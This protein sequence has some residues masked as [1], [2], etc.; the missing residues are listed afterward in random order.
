VL[1]E[2]CDPGQH[3][4]TKKGNLRQGRWKIG[5]YDPSVEPQGI[6]V[7][8]QVTELEVDWLSTNILDDGRSQASTPT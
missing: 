3:V 1:I 7:D 5:A 2:F 8:V 4:L 6:V